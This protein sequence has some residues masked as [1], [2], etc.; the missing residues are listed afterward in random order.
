MSGLVTEGLVDPFGVGLAYPDWI[1]VTSPAAG[2]TVSVSV[3]GNWS[4]RV[5]SARATITTDANAANRLVTLDYIN[6]RA[7]TYA[8]NGFAGVITANTTAQAIEW[9]RNRGT[10]EWATNTP[11]F[12]CLLDTILP[13]GFSV[14]FNVGAIQ[15]G[16][17]LS[18]IHLAVEKFPTGPRGIA[19]G[20]V[21]T[22]NVRVVEHEP[23]RV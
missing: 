16:D 11:I 20:Q 9:Q 6:G 21:P 17:Q 2:S 12:A 3:D 1:D 19:R 14:K 10:G 13:P 4:L 15:A 7:V 22:L 8:Q 18:G 23:S 5:I